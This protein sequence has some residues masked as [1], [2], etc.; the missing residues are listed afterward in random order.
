MRTTC[1]ECNTPLSINTVDADGVL[2]GD[3]CP[4][5]GY[6]TTRYLPGQAPV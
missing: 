4:K 3:E 5:C 2:I 1:D 6:Y